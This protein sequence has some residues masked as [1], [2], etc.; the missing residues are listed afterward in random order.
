MISDLFVVNKD[1]TGMQNNWLKV[2]SKLPKIKSSM[3]DLISNAD[4]TLSNEAKTILNK[5]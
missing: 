4:I 5:D 3:G 2:M 1:R